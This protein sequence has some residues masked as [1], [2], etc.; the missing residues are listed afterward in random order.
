MNKLLPGAIASFLLLGLT[1]SAWAD[2]VAEAWTC[3][4]NEGKTIADAQAV[5]KRWIAWMRA[6]VNEKI[7]STAATPV[8]ADLDVIAYFD[9]YPDIETWAVGK[10]KQESDEGKAIE[11]SFAEVLVCSSNRLWKLY[12]TE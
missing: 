4:L 2:S 12:S 8:V 1:G 10:A 11:S 7:T 9:T 5:N 6:N 3:K